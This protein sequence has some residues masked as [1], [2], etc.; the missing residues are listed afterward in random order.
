MSNG[1]ERGGRLR[2]GKE[3][4]RGDNA[5]FDLQA[6][7]WQSDEAE[8]LGDWVFVFDRQPHH[9]R[10]PSEVAQHGHWQLHRDEIRRREACRVEP[11]VLEVRHESVGRTWPNLNHRLD[12][13]C[14]VLLGGM[15][16]RDIELAAPAALM[17]D[18]DGS[19]RCEQGGDDDDDRKISH[20]G[21]QQATSM[22][23][24]IC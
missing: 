10:I 2:A 8:L 13:I 3:R 15:D 12:G 22:P 18:G 4:G 14:V 5:P 6:I 16:Q 17:L 11:V 24:S 20:D 9:V 19:R 23:P 1:R 21:V 7:V